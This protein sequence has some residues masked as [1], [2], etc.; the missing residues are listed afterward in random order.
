MFNQQAF[1][2]TMILIGC[3]CALFMGSVVLRYHTWRP[4]QIGGFLLMVL[5]VAAAV[6]HVAWL[7]A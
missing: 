6:A 5:S 2:S 4:M 7:V 3:V 1:V